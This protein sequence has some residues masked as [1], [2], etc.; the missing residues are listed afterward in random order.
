MPVK[1]II[2]LACAAAAGLLTAA[3]ILSGC[4]VDKSGGTE[5][6][7]T[8]AFAKVTTGQSV[9]FT[10]TGGFVYHWSLS[11]NDGTGVLN[12]KLGDTVVYTCLRSV[13]NSVQTLHVVSTFEGL[14]TAPSNGTWQADAT[15]VF[16]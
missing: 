6:Q 15:I 7:I 11:P 13:S 2:A 16:Q 3:L 10:A 4:E 12:T 5:V 1:R 14:T 9:S 8:P